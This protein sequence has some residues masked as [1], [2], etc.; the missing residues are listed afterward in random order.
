MAAKA[1]Q[2]LETAA[3]IVAGDRE[4]AFVL[5][6]DAA[7]FVGEALLAQQGLRST[8]A[9]GHVAVSDAVRAQFA[10]PFT[11]LNS[12]RRRR[13]ELEYPSVPGERIE[14]DEITTAIGTT[15]ALLAAADS[16]SS[17][18]ACSPSQP[19]DHA[20]RCSMAGGRVPR[21]TDQIPRL[22]PRSQLELSNSSIQ[23]AHDQRIRIAE[24]RTARRPP[25]VA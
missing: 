21:R 8:Q 2:R 4:S 1:A 23:H 16:S 20:G 24:P 6:Y 22:M 18:S 9:G 7:R 15:R 14:P 13:N 11:A 12:L 25:I 17:T 3:A 10:G 19:A 5:T